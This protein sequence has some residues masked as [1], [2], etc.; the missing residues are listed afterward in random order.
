MKFFLNNQII[1]TDQAL[2]S[3]LLDFIR[4][5]QGL[6]GT[7]EVCREGDCG[8]CSVLVG[9]LGNDVICYKHVCSCLIPLGEMQG[10]HVV[11]IEGLNQPDALNPIQQA[12]VNHGAVQCGFCTPGFVVAMTGYFLNAK[13]FSRDEFLAAMS[14]NICRCTGYV[15]IRNAAFALLKEF[16]PKLKRV[17]NRIEA[18]VALKVLPEYFVGMAEE[19]KKVARSYGNNGKDGNYVG[20]G[21]DLFVQKAAALVEA[22][23]TF[24]LNNAKLKKIWADQAHLYI[25]GA[26]TTEMLRESEAVCKV[27][28]NIVQISECISS[29][30]IRHRATIAGNI[31]NASPIAD[32]AI[33]LLSL[34]AELGLNLKGKKRT[35]ALKKFYRGYKQMNLKP[36][37]LIEWIRVPLSMSRLKKNFEKVAKRGHLD[38]ASVNS[39][40]A[41]EFDDSRI[42]SMYLSAGGV[43]PYP[44]FLSKTCEEAKGQAISKKFIEK[45]LTVIDSEIAPISDVRGNADYKRLLLKQLVKGHFEK[46]GGIDT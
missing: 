46:L 10:K 23:S 21:T 38:I 6:K 36:G 7:K 11:T 27:I 13:T 14:G 15:S 31:V 28:P 18:L 17:K 37:E 40:M 43:F 9:E 39:A 12:M 26:A 5:D 42:K 30:P 19:L 24:L 41:L 44:L 45:L 34:N 29:Q 8:A 35:L 3:V 2:G 16:A 33:L 4:R 20:G 32:L 1:E 25:G 22:K